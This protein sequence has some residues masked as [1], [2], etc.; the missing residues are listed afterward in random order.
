MPDQYQ[1]G[2]R[3]RITGH[4]KK[5]N[6]YKAKVEGTSY[7]KAGLPITWDAWG[8]KIVIDAG[9]IVGKRTVQSGSTG[10]EAGYSYFVP[11]PGTAQTVYL[12]A[13]SLHRKPFMVFPDQIEPVD[14]LDI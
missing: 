3:V 14:L 8:H 12:V 6:D 4:T 1:L 9:I 5:V 11:E 10:N 2:Q 7:P 13:H